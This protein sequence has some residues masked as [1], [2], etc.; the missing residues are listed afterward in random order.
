M[1]RAARTK[2]EPAGDRYVLEEQAG[3]ILRQVNQRHAGIFTA[4]MGHDLT[5]TQWAAMA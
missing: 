5:P 4:V 2:A 1:T 3:F